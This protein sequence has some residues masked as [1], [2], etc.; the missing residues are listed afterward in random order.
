MTEIKTI[1]RLFVDKRDLEDFKRLREKDSPFSKSANKDIFLAA[2]V[3]GFNEQCKMEL[4][5]KEGWMMKSYLDDRD[6]AL[7][8][9]IAIAED[10]NL[11]VLL[12]EPKVFSIAEQYAAGGIRLLKDRV[13]GVDFG[14]YSKRLESKLLKTY[15]K[16]MKTK[17]KK[18]ST[19]EE[20]FKYSTDDLLKMDENEKVEFK[21]SLIW[22]YKRKQKDKKIGEI[23]A[24]TISCFMNSKGGVLLIG[25]N[26]Q[27]KVLGL[28]QDLKMLENRS[29]DEFE[30]YFTNVIK[31]CL[32]T[33]Y[34][35]YI[36]LK[37]EKSNKKTVCVVRVKRSPRPVYVKYKNEPQFY[38]RQG[39]SCQPLNIKEAN[40]Y[41]KENWPD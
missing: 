30:I 12:D 33:L 28:E 3:V 34:R 6:L 4:K 16:I 39:N 5:S 2:M 27:K 9:A 36:D 14:S 8:R 18:E 7:I 24:K 23:V 15:E 29:Q 31:K 1:D 21:S 11:N 32:G 37:F 38:V 35:K 10:G 40:I 22:D 17:Q 41:I 20:I 25:V 26:N 19:T 13:F